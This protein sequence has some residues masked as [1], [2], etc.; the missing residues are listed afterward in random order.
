[1]KLLSVLASLRLTLPGM[2]LL[3]AGVLVRYLADDASVLWIAMPLLLLAINL[4]AALLVNPRFH[5]QP[6]LLMFHIC[7]LLL[8]LLAIAGQLTSLEARLEISEGQAFSVERVE[9]LRQGPWHPRERLHEVAFVQGPLHV[10][11]RPGLRRGRT[12]SHLLVNGGDQGAGLTAV[13]DNIPLKMAGY[14]FYT[15]PNKGFA[16]VLTWHDN[17]G[18]ELTGAVNFPSYPAN[19]WRQLNAWNSP[20]GAVLS[21]ELLFAEK[22]SHEQSWTLASDGM[23]AALRIT[24]GTETG[25]L[26]PG[27]QI[28]IGDALVRFDAVRMWMGYEI[29]YEPL[30]PWFFT[31]AVIGVIALGWHFRTRL[32]S[33][34]TVTTAVPAGARQGA[35]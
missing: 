33:Q 30:L 20:D 13:G 19:D 23:S 16:A 7:L 6:A 25:I 31:T 15:T 18:N 4:L 17:A 2:L 21:L 1:M 12:E 24:S 22:P 29:R 3:T 26:Y 27:G 32:T 14:R 8:V 9:I 10:D 34:Q 5:R 28:Q 35:G 11:Y